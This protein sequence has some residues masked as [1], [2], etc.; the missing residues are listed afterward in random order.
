VL[1]TTQRIVFFLIETTK[2]GS[3]SFVHLF[4]LIHVMA[5]TTQGSVLYEREHDLLTFLG[6][7][8]G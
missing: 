6:S 5:H 1:N 8:L 2:L 4:I 3:S 7:N